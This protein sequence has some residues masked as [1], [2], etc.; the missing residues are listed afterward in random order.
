MTFPYPSPPHLKSPSRILIVR[1]SAHGDVVHTLPLLAALKK[2]Y[3]Q[4]FVGWLVETSAA[5]LLQNHPLIDQLHVSP[6]KQWLTLAKNPLN[7]P[8]IAAELRTLLKELQQADYQVSLDV[9]GLLK[10][11]VWPALAKI[12]HRYGF[13]KTRELGDWFYT[14][15]LP[16]HDLKNT[17]IPVTERFLDFAHVLGAAVEAP[18]FII[19]PVAEA[20]RQKVDALLAGTHPELPLIVLAPFTRWES[21]HW[22]EDA[23]LQVL[24]ELLHMPVRIA[25]IGAP[26]DER[27]TLALLA[28]LPNSADAERILN[29]V[30][31]TD[32][33]DLYA[34][35]QRTRLMI[36]LDSGPLHIANAV[37]VPEIIGLYGPTAAGR[38][39][40]L[41][42]AHT[43]LSTAL[44]CQPCY[45]HQCPL[46]THAC[47]QQLTPVA[48][49]AMVRKHLLQ[50]MG[51]D[52][53]RL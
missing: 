42:T 11:A 26:G 52:P 8:R 27:A 43:T 49:L 46:K 30:G 37:G 33:P 15:K 28:Q 41:G 1:L 39:G 32:W 6:R 53:V 40:P 50:P 5:S 13:R 14:H 16:Y 35:F 38:T 47:M 2:Q 24:A 12:P 25:L 51:V 19:P 17:H 22:R 4:A 21:K 18:E 3:P 31:K 7:W 34:L 29:W 44:S 48:V 9:Q 23:W 45:K 10:S 36:G 20:S